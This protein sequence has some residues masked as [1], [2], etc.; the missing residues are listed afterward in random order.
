MIQDILLNSNWIDA[1]LLVLTLRTIFIGI[2]RGLMVEFFKFLAILFATFLTLHF[3]VQLGLFFHEMVSLPKAVQESV[4]FLVL[5]GAVSLIFKFI[6]E[7]WNL[8][9]KVEEL[10]F[11]AKIS[12]GVLAAFRGTLIGGLILFF[13]VLTGNKFLVKSARQSFVGFYLQELSPRLYNVMFDGLVLKL[14]P[15]EKKNE[16]VFTLDQ[17][18]SQSP[19]SK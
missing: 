15:Q 14:F 3:Y 1:I 6:G 11:F 13:L 18:K 10:S 12:G 16:K 4:A 7:G 17:Q 8:I 19:A 5:W 9:H 2:K